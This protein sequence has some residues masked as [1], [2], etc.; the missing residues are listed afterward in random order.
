[1]WNDVKPL[2]LMVTSWKYCQ[3]KI[4]FTEHCSMVIQIIINSEIEIPNTY[5]IYTK[6]L[7]ITYQIIINY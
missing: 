6:Y 3:M 2:E 7:L 5:L 4:H 1:M